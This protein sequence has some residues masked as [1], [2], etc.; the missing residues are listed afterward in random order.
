MARRYQTV[1]LS[2]A[3]EYIDTLSETD[4]GTLA[5]DID[6][7]RAGELQIPYTKKLSGRIRELISGPH[8]V[9]YFL[10]G[11]IIYF[12]RGFKKQSGKTPKKEIEYAEQIYKQATK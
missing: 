5:A 1:F 12:V 6:F 7:M 11:Y 3:Q 2:P 8:R 10:I 9:T 4:K